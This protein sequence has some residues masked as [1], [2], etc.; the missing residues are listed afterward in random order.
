MSDY[1][2]TT[3]EVK[4]GFTEFENA[5]RDLDEVETGFDRWLARELRKAKE[6][7]W[8]MGALVGIAAALNDAT[9]LL[10]NPYRGENK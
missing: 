3:E 1:I 2:P 5:F 10:A 4:N 6:E 9:E 7:A 8:G